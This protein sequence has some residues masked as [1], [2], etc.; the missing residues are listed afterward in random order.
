VTLR[1]MLPAYI[2]NDPADRTDAHAVLLCQSFLQHSARLVSTADL[3]YIVVRQSAHAIARTVACATFVP[4]V[5]KVLGLRANEQVVHVAARAVVA[6]VAH[7]LVIRNRP[8]DQH[9]REAMGIPRL[10]FAAP[11]ISNL[12]VPV[13]RLASEPR[14]APGL[15]WLS[16]IAVQSVLGWGRN[17]RSSIGMFHGQIIGACFVVRGKLVG[18]TA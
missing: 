3:A 12:A 15:C 4:H 8:V 11:D 18:A 16:H 13:V 9:P 6:L 14:N 7:L 17:I 1:N 5:R 10:S 2:A